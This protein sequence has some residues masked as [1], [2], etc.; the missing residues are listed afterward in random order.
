MFKLRF[1][2]VVDWS[3]YDFFRIKILQYFDTFLLHQSDTGRREEKVDV[4]PFQQIFQAL[5]QSQCALLLYFSQ[6][7]LSVQCMERKFLKE[8]LRYK[9]F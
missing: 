3:Q 1:L 6:L 4:I 2:H 8:P 7:R 5:R 9:K